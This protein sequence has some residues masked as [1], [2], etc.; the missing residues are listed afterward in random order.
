MWR[1]RP[2]APT[3][4]MHPRASALPHP[5]LLLSYSLLDNCL[6]IF[7]LPSVFASTFSPVSNASPAIDRYKYS[8]VARIFALTRSLEPPSWTFYFRCDLNRPDTDSC[9]QQL[10]IALLFL[11]H[12]YSCHELRPTKPATRPGLLMCEAQPA[13]RLS[14]SPPACQFRN[15]RARRF[16]DF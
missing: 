15:E 7:L 13:P 4:S 12:L 3:F 8:A 5:I 16:H 14:A 9:S 2:K 6:Y 1:A 11:A 10:G